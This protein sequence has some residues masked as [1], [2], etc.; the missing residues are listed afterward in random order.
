MLFNSI[1]FFIFFPIVF[2]LYWIGKSDRWQNAVLLLASYVFYGW[3][4]WK[5]LALVLFSSLLCYGSGILIEKYRDTDQR[6]A[7]VY[8]CLNIIVNLAVLGVFKY[9]DFFAQSFADVFLGGNSEGLLLKLVLPVGISFYTFKALSYT[10]EIK[11]GTI[12]AERNPAT[13]LTYIGFF[14]QLL[15]GPIERPGNLIPQ[16]KVKRVFTYEQG[17]DGMRQ[18]LW[19]LFK[20]VVVADNCAIFVNEIW[21]SYGDQAGSTLM[22]AAIL[23]CF[24]IYGDFSGYSDMAIGIGKM[25]GITA[26]QNFATPYFSRNIAEFWR[27]WHISLTSW[28]RDYVYIPLGGNRCP[29]WR[30]IFNTF[31]IFILSGLWHGANWTFIVWGA[32][33]AVLFVPGLLRARGRK[34]YKDTVAEGRILPDIKECAQMLITFVLVLFGWILFRADSIT[35]AWDYI[36][37]MAH[38]GTLKAPLFLF[39]KPVVRTQ[40]I[41]ICIVTLAEWYSRN[42]EHALSR[43][44]KNKY[45]R[46][47]IYVLIAIL[48][49]WFFKTDSGFIYQQF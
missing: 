8:N 18:I 6:K 36:S 10:I 7:K 17:A 5:F 31:V 3:W 19:G 33:N 40:C 30:V 22:L 42:N 35:Q 34:R 11:R 39:T 9:Y 32:Y 21:A 15:A 16:L 1:E 20:K 2:A 26:R 41:G 23:Y 14:P 46:F 37:G 47:T 43:L 4:D 45:L 48:C 13:V 44:P 24:Q 49:W 28:F 38:L 12:E 29:K 27:R 25:F